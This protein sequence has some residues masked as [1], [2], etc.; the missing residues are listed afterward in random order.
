M[1]PIPLFLFAFSAMRAVHAI[2][3]HNAGTRTRDLIVAVRSHASPAD[4][5][6]AWGAMGSDRQH[7]SLDDVCKRFGPSHKSTD[8]VQQWAETHGAI[9]I[10]AT[11][12]RTPCISAGRAASPALPNAA[13]G[14]SAR[15]HVTLLLLNT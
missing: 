4:F 11:R 2:P 6:A 13:R 15:I 12:F 10:T 3:M 8:A 1:L 9:R 5:Q 7:M 14:L